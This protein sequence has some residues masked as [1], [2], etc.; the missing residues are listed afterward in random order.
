MRIKKKDIVV[1]ISG[2]Y[3]GKRGEVIKFLGDRVIVDG[4]NIRKKHVKPRPNKPSGIIE[5]PMPIHISNVMLVCNKCSMPTRIK[6]A[7]MGEKKV[8][9][10]MRCGEF[11]L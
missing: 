11:I 10:C 4:V 6:A 7:Y 9:K 3:K 1:V 8:R 2:P 5:T